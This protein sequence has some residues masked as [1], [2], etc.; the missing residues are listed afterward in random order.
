MENRDYYVYMHKNKINGKVYIGITGQTPKER[1]GKNGNGYKGSTHFYNAIQK[2]GWDNF[3]HI[4]LKSGITK[5]D[6]EKIEVELIK[7]YNSADRDYGYN[8]QLGGNSFGKMSDEI[9]DKIS[10]ANKGKYVGEKGPLY[11][12]HRPEEVKKAI[13][14]ANGK[15]VYQYDRNTGKF[16]AEF[17]SMHDAGRK[18]NIDSSIIC[19]VCKYKVKSIGGY[20]FRYKD[21][22]KFKYGDPLSEEDM[23]KS[24]DTRMRKVRQYTKNNEFVAE[25]NSIRDAELYFNKKLG[26]TL[27]WHCCNGKKPSALGYVWKYA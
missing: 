19:S 8:M 20:I 15:H 1:W 12:K 14:D 22:S 9:K 6:A 3:E 23:E 11:G 2:Y 17:S 7:K 25:F 26:N 4:I 10:K 18:L 16:I 27:I 5:E 13:A 24:R 21:D